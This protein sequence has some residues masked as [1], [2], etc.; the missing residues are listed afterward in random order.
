MDSATFLAELA[1][2]LRAIKRRRLATQL[3][4]QQDTGVDQATVSRVLNGQRKR[5]TEPIERLME[6]ANML[7]EADELSSYVQEAARQF[8]RRGGSEAELIASIEHSAKLV[9]RKLR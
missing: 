1:D 2:R 9:S 4:I 8:L 7:L 5:V 6:Y 3:E